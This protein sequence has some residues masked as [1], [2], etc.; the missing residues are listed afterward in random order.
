MQR[1]GASWIIIKENTEAFYI[2]NFENYLKGRIL[3]KE[4]KKIRLK[5]GNEH[6]IFL[7]LQNHSYYG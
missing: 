2:N 7:L 1:G 5:W 6:E 4:T 3:K